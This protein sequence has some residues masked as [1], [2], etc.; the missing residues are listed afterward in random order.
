[1]SDHAPRPWYINDRATDEYHE[2][3]VGG[4][5]LPMLKQLKILRSIVVNLGLIALSG[6]TVTQ[7]GD[8]TIIGG[9]GLVVLG[10]YNGLEVSDYLALLRA[11][12]EI[13]NQ[14]QDDSDRK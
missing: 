7:G 8:P 11:Y 3:L 2:T 12:D 10:A 4:G 1:M 13:Q 5:E 14:N 9:L 6:L